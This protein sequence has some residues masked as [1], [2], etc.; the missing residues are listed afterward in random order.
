MKCNQLMWR[1]DILDGPLVVNEIC[2]WEKKNKK[3]VLM[4]KAYF[5]K[6]FDSINWEFLDSNLMQMGFGDK[7]R[8]WIKGCLQSSHTS[9]LINGNPTDEFK[10]SKGFQHGDPL[11]PFLFIIAMEGLSVAMR[12]SC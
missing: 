1:V 10:I 6:A 2:S 5:D 3:K 9:V 11:S 8:M 12:A 4:F 7:W